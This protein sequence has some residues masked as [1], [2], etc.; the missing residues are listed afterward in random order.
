MPPQ[1]QGAA[2]APDREDVTPAANRRDVLGD[3]PIAAAR[4]ALHDFAL[5]VGVDDYPGFHSLHGAVNDARAFH[6]WV[7]DPEGGG[8]AQD[9]A[10]LVVSAPDPV[11]PLQDDIDAKLVEVMAAADELGGGRRLYF[12]FS[13]HGASNLGGPN[14]DVALLVA[15][16][17]ENLARFA[18]SS[19]DYSS[20]IGTDGLFEEITVFLDCCRTA[21]SVGVIGRPPAMTYKM[22]SRRYPSTLTFVA[23]AAEAGRPAFETPETAL[24]QGVFTRSLLQILRSAPAGISA[25]DLKAQLE[26]AVRTGGAGQQPQVNNQLRAEASFGSRGALPRLRVTFVSARGRVRLLDGGGRKLAEHEV[27]PDPWELALGVSLYKLVDEGGRSKLIDH[28][29]QE[30]TDVTF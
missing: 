25:A 11:R 28:G 3:A 10:R 19:R 4:A 7:T 27:T 12:Y 29:V 22:T 6:A 16:W 26:S 24:W 17:S 5:V 14:D 2:A 18:L 1:D 15:N 23:H 13:G 30:I 21:S 9:R 20:K 8:V